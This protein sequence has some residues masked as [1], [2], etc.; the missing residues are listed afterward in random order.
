MMADGPWRVA[1]LFIAV[2]V[3]SNSA[4]AE[5]FPPRLPSVVLLSTRPRSAFP[6][7][8]GPEMA[9]PLCD[10]HALD[11]TVARQFKIVT[12]SAT[13]CA[14]RRKA[15]R[16]DPYATFSA[17]W[18]RSPLVRVEETSC[19]GACKQAPCVAVEHD[20]Y[21]GPVAL[22]GMEPS[23]FSDRVFHRIVSDDDADR[24]WGIVEKAIYHMANDNAEEQDDIYESDD[25]FV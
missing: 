16:L 13:S 21:D 11:E 12:C 10:T 22:T 15:L 7:V 9:D 1:L 6:M 17:F 25:G 20:D 8:L 14:A 2:V 5:C 24:V 18:G 19:L 4:L 23:E 3:V